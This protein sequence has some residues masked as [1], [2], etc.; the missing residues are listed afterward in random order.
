M[1][2]VYRRAASTGARELAG[3]LEGKRFRALQMPMASR[4]RRGDVVICWGE[5]L[6]PIPGVQI[7][8]GAAIQSKM[9]DAILLLAAQVPTIQVSRTRPAPVVVAPVVDPALA[10]F[11]RA[12]DLAD[13]FSNLHEFAR[14]PVLTQGVREL[15]TAIE[16]LTRQMG[17]PLPAPVV[18]PTEQ[19]WIPRLFDHVGGNDILTVTPTPDYWSKKE[20]IVKEFRIHSF[21]GKS[22]RAGVKAHREGMTP[23]PWIRSWDGGW[24]ILYDGVSSKQ[25]HRDLAHRAVT[26]LGLQFG[27]VDIGERADES[28]IV[29][30]VNRA[31]GLDGGTVE[32]YAHAIESWLEETEGRR[33]A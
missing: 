14:T 19:T 25:R 13:E 1:V 18:V 11:E 5:R 23:H 3:A 22:I 32:V 12:R 4:V 16:G 31:P 27:A 2:Y 20:A 6:D 30:E 7:L 26:A 17:I 8:N 10:L 28:L 15:H 9:Q 24:R 33:A 29:L 21:Q